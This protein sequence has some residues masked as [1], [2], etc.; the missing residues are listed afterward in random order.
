MSYTLYDGTVFMAQ[1]ALLSLRRILQ[2]AEKHAD[3]GKLIAARLIDDMKPLTFQVRY[4]CFSAQSMA[5]ELQGAEAG[6][7]DE[8]EDDELY[9]FEKLHACID[10]A[11]A[12]LEGL[13][14]EAVNRAGDT[15]TT[16]A[17]R[18]SSFEVPVRAVVGL[19]RMPNVYF[20]VSMAYAI[21]R[22]EG[23]PVGKRDWS[24][25]FLRDYLEQDS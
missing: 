6:A 20:H 18:G 7:F 11:V 19:M 3:S 8:T 4:A 10:Q 9:S 15:M 23:V 2:H 16:F 1:G 22:K 24:R 25:P 5:I 17:R 21:L 13:D 12:A 14:P